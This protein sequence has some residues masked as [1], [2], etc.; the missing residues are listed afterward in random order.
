M[1]KEF[2]TLTEAHFLDRMYELCQ[3]LL[4]EALELSNNIRLDGNLPALTPRNLRQS[5]NGDQ[6]LSETICAKLAMEFYYP[7]HQDE[8]SLRWAATGLFARPL[9]RPSNSQGAQFVER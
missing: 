7:A 9:E 4:M 5:I 1:G 6:Q 8:A 2:L 3:F